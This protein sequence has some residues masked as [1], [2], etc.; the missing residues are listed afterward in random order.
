MKRNAR[1]FRF[2]EIKDSRKGVVKIQE[3]SSACGGPYVWIFYKDRNGDD[4]VPCVGAKNGWLS[5]S[6]H[7]TRA[8]ARR[9]AKALQEWAK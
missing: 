7:L 9:V 4:C 6:P 2:K 3:S 8:Q 1:G 5:N